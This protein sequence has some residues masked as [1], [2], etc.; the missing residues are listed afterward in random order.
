MILLDRLCRP[1]KTKCEATAISFNGGGIRCYCL[2]TKMR[3]VYKV[4]LGINASS[5]SFLLV[6]RRHDDI[7]F[8]T[9]DIFTF[10]CPRCKYLPSYAT[11]L[12]T[13]LKELPDRQRASV[14]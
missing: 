6:A 12:M 2:E 7:I 8:N 1:A 5:W 4:F 10:S 11:K 9:I 14:L 13:V 3:C